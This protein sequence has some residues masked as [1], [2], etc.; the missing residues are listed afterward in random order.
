MNYVKVVWFSVQMRRMTD[1]CMN[2]NFDP[3][4]TV[5]T[6]SF[7]LFFVPTQRYD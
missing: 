4:M 2:H 1:V 7:A 6:F 3:D 5:E